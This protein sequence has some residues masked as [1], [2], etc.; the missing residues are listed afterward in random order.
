[1]K[2]PKRTQG[3]DTFEGEEI[4]VTV[5]EEGD[6]KI[7]QRVVESFKLNEDELQTFDVVF[8][9][10]PLL[11]Y[12]ETVKNARAN[13]TVLGHGLKVG[14]VL[15]LQCEGAKD[16]KE[17]LAL[18][19]SIQSYYPDTHFDLIESRRT[20]WTRQFLFLKVEDTV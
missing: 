10:M 4:N 12:D 18:I 17:R 2:Q 14:G 15:Y 6:L 1:M 8:D 3:K 11:K 7:E 16:R 9:E 5:I 19:K 13:T 20:P